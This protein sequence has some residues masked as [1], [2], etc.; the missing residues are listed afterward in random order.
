MKPH[1]YKISSLLLG[2]LSVITIA[3][4]EGCTQKT[5]NNEAPTTIADNVEVIFDW[6]K[7]PDT[8]ASSMNL[9]L[10]SEDHDVMNHWFKNRT[11]GFIK[12]YGGKHTAICHTNDDP[13]IH[14]LRNQHAHNE[15]EI[16]TDNSSVL[17][18]QGIS[19]YRLPRANG[20]ENEPLR[21]TPTMIYGAQHS[22]ID[23]KVTS[24]LQTITLYPEELVC[25]YTVEFV[26]V[27]N[28][29][30]ADLRID[31]TIS[32][33]AGGYYPGRMSATSEAV[34]H[35]FTL[36]ADEQLTSLSSEFYTFGLPVGEQRPHKLCIYIALKNRQGNLY[37]YDV[38]DQ[39]N[40]APDPRHVNI[41]IS[42]LELPYVPPDP[43]SPPEQ[44]GVSVEVDSWETIHF[45][46][47]V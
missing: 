9:Y 37:T 5:L 6:S 25:H 47:K 43:P 21:M 2:L 32:S 34:T 29:N 35:P 12:S 1:W 16:Y 7:A 24:F 39:V 4:T 46:V 8:Q 18:G 19:T 3:L 10:Y 31:G 14:Y 27:K 41:K 28:L 15:F 44:G 30:S 38:S 36:T 17:V 11:G 22:E 26:D 45:G 20:T 33:L 42:G 40:N 13:Y 23:L